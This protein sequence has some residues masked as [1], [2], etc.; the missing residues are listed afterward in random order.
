MLNDGD[1]KLGRYYDGRTVIREGKFTL[2]EMHDEAIDICME[3]GKCWVDIYTEEVHW[4]ADFLTKDERNDIMRK[5]AKMMAE[6]VE[7]GMR[8]DK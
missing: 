6:S 5:V 7:K 1:L 2:A 4:H 8:E 3:E